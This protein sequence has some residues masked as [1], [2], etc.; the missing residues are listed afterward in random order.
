MSYF[1]KFTDFCAG[2][3]AFVAAMFF[4]RKYMA[5]VPKEPPDPS[6]ATSSITEAATDVIEQISEQ[7]TEKF[8]SKLEQ[9]LEPTEK[10]DYSL[11]IPLIALL[12]VSAILGRVLKKLPYVCFGISLLPAMM[13]AYMFETDTLHTQTPLFLIV[14]VLHVVGN[15][16]DCLIRDKEDGGHRAWIAAKISSAMG[17]LLCFGVLWKGARPRPED[18]SKINHFE[19]KVFFEMT[20]NDVS[21][22]TQ[23]GWM[24][25]ILLAISLLLYNVYFIDAIVSL[26]PTT[27]VIYQC[28]GEYLTL[29]PMLFCT[30]AILCTVTHIALTVFE[31]NLSKKEQKQQKKE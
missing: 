15:I 6:K 19:H 5:F 16:A 10:A 9:F 28:A 12:L 17:A 23:L 8:P 24:F 14:A 11:L 22:L 3:A 13:I 31:N 26:I 27:F 18:A 4:M 30:V 29:A 25:L 20:E 21:L 2:F 7:V 1:K